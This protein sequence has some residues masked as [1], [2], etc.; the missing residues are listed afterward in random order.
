MRSLRLAPLIALL[1]LTGC[2][3]KTITR[4]VT[5]P[6]APTH[7]EPNP[8]PVQSICIP[9]TDPE[10][11]A[12]CHPDGATPVPPTPAAEL[13]PTARSV[14]TIDSDGLRIIE[15]FEGYSRCAYFDRFG[16]VWTAGFGQTRGIFGGFCYSGRAAAEADLAGSVRRSYEPAVRAIGGP[17]GQHQINAL[18]SF[19]YN[20]GP[21]IFTGSLRADLRAGRFFSA[22]QIMLRYVHAGGV[23]LAGLVTRRRLECHELLRA[24]RPSETPAQHRARVHRERTARL[25]RD[26]RYRQ[27]LRAAIRGHRCSHGYRGFSR[28]HR[29]KCTTWRN[30]GAAV[31]RDIRRLRARGIR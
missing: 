8:P 2:A 19:A 30:R 21:G 13:G 18:D 23:T 4:T 12:G 5:S 29:R 22:C 6:A 17:F 11:G 15:Q 7:E 26:Y 20:L 9:S 28:D 10:V 24:S 27:G 16:G 1:V 31:R 14:P 3:T 25:H